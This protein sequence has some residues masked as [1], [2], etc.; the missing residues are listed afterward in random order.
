MR[1]TPM[2]T[3]VRVR[4]LECLRA[5]ERL[6]NGGGYERLSGGQNEGAGVVK[7]VCVRFQNGVG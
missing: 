1:C 4:S 2:R 3:R 6:L 5:F 7:I